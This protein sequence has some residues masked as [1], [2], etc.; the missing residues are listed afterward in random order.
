MSDCKLLLN[1][2]SSV[3]VNFISRDLNV[4]AHRLV[5]HAMH[6]GCKSWMGY[7]FPLDENTVCCN[8]STVI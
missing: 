7:A 6:V 8:S 1:A 5:G 4:L 3:S 2:F